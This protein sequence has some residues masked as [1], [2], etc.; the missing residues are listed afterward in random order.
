MD[1]I[2]FHLQMQHISI[3]QNEKRYYSFCWL[4][5]GICAG[6]GGRLLEIGHQGT[7]GSHGG[8]IKP[9]YICPPAV[10]KHRKNQFLIHNR[11]SQN[12]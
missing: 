3:F 12:I 7:E 1:E 9:T 6:C 2:F 10:L 11:G 5:P 4:G 8:Y